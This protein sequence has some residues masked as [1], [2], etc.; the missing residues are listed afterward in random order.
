MVT[1][2]EPLGKTRLAFASKMGSLVPAFTVQMTAVLLDA[3]NLKPLPVRVMKGVVA[4]AAERA[5]PKRVRA[6]MTRARPRRA[7]A[8]SD[9]GK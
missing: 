5:L 4:A 3:L 9:R 6:T 1:T 2:F 8:V 7:T